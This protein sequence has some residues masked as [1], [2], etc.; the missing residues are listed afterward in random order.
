MTV[1]RSRVRGAT[2]AI[3]AALVLAIIA[4]S[5]VF[6]KTGFSNELL[7]DGTGIVSFA[8]SVLAASL[9]YPLRDEIRFRLLSTTAILMAIVLGF[10]FLGGFL[11]F[12][13]DKLV[14]YEQKR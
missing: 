13:L 9:F 2:A 10:E 4:L 12:V 6:F 7:I 5:S 11:W 14:R 1:S 3:L 8:L